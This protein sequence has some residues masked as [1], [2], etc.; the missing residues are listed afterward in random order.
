MLT[1]FKECNV[2]MSLKIY[3]LYNHLNFF[4]D[5][6]SDEKGERFHQDLAKIEFFYHS[7]EMA[8]PKSN[9]EV[10][11]DFCKPTMEIILKSSKIN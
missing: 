3:F 9:D 4:P 7:I 10:I 1:A 5:N 11:R 2:H 6:W 8:T